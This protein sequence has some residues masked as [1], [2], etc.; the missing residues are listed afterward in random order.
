MN[1]PLPE[2]LRSWA[3][4]ES[5]PPDDA[6]WGA[7]LDVCQDC[8]SR[9]DEAMG[10]ARE[11]LVLHGLASWRTEQESC[12]PTLKTVLA[13]DFRVT[14]VP[15]WTEFPFVEHVEGKSLSGRLGRLEL[16]EW[17]GAGAMGVVF[18]AEDPA[19]ERVVAVKVLRPEYAGD[20]KVAALF[21][22]EARAAAGLRHEAIL[23]IYD[24]FEEA[25]EDGVRAGY[26]MPPVD[27]GTLA[28][29]IREGGPCST[30]DFVRILG[31]IAAALEAAHHAGILHRDV[32]PAN[33]L[34]EKDGPG[35]WLS[36]FGL[37]RAARHGFGSGSLVGTPGYVAPE[38]ASGG[39]GTAAADWYGLGMVAV[40]LI[41]GTLPPQGT[42]LEGFLRNSVHFT[43]DSNVPVI[44]RLLSWALSLADPDP[45]ARPASGAKTLADALASAD[46]QAAREEKARDRGRRWA[47][48]AAT[49]AVLLAVVTGS[50]ALLGW[51]TANALLC[52]LGADKVSVDGRLGTFASVGEALEAV[53]G[54]ATVRVGNGDAVF[55]TPWP[56]LEGRNLVIQGHGSSG[57][58]G[59]AVAKEE[60]IRVR[61]GSLRLVGL[62]LRP[63]KSLP[64]Q[65]GFIEV[66]GGSLSI[67]DCSI[68]RLSNS[69]KGAV[70]G[71]SLL[72]LAGDVRVE[73]TSSH[74]LTDREGKAILARGNVGTSKSILIRNS[75][76]AGGGFLHVVA[77]DPGK[78]EE[79][80]A[81]DL[82]I[83]DSVVISSAAIRLGRNGSQ[84]RLAIHS[85][86]NL[87]Q[88][89]EVLLSVRENDPVQ[90]RNRLNF[91]D[92]GSLFAVGGDRA[93]EWDASPPAPGVQS[94]GDGA[95]AREDW[96]SF[97]ERDTGGEWVDWIVRFRP[98]KEAIWNEALSL[99]GRGG[100][101]VGFLKS[102]S[103]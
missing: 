18:R 17:I 8:R 14:V 58:E 72:F 43:D 68:R 65:S 51:R 98:G 50:E 53:A 94:S 66:E 21:L 91:K 75:G 57:S 48:T 15:D 6:E 28:D 89:N 30:G 96:Q 29:R 5:F 85:L 35:V 47:R 74:F 56:V 67:E 16:K 7:H 77:S 84:T 78:G 27:G 60:R 11:A 63:R 45:L 76:F 41:C 37:A 34:L 2:L 103:G 102:F 88:G 62:E 19:L 71:G 93:V 90:V 97:W 69:V 79:A 80:G 26:V 70:G 23:P 38:V 52:R 33:I 100:S 95:K 24:V 73:V 82:E 3:Q 81:I 92:E 87:W 61:G 59:A 83:T 44:D 13:R 40:E 12:L 22:D 42:D 49:W 4:G 31:R 99:E 64:S 32:K 54:D 101:V 1:C 39:E 55:A 36:D 25:G 9:V 86:R 46:L 10:A 20:E